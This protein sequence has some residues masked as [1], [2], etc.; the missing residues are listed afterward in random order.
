MAL[1]AASLVLVNV[2]CTGTQNRSLTEGNTAKTAKNAPKS[3]VVEW[4][5]GE[6]ISVIS[7]DPAAGEPAR[8]A[9]RDYLERAFAL[10]TEYGLKPLGSVPV[11][12]AVVGA[13]APGA[14]AFYSWPDQRSEAALANDPRWPAIKAR[15]PAG[16]D[17]L[18]VHDVVA[19]RP[20]SLRFSADKTYTMAT[21]WLNAEHPDDYDRYL[22]N[23]ATAVSEVGGRFILDLQAPD[24]EAHA[25]DG[26][27][28]G[29]V[30]FVEWDSPAALQAF[31]DT[32]GFKRNVALLQSGTTAFELLVLKFSG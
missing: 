5:P 10:A 9:R 25:F 16:W 29:R 7:V 27:A 1:M 14:V 24:F 3:L 31:Q 19:D 8:Q 11:S 12:G 20:V 17:E 15:R 6:V 13:F 30:V 26:P 18:R 2:G 4:R 21:A 28:P 32:A 23:I 22:S